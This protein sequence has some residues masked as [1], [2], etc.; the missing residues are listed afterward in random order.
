MGEELVAGAVFGDGA[1]L[2]FD[3]RDG[4]GEV[5]GW[6]SQGDGEDG[7]EPANGAV[8]GETGGEGFLPA[9]AFQVQGKG[10]AGLEGLVGK[11]EG[12]EEEVVD[13]GAVGGGGLLEQGG[14]EVRGKGDSVAEGV[15]F[16]S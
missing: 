11:G 9:V 8:E 3:G 4:V 14:G 2:L 13:A 6:E 5:T 1:K 12:G 10:R 7:G 16:E 15:G